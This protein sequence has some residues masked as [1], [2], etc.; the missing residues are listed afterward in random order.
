MYDKKL[1]NNINKKNINPLNLNPKL[2]KD[3]LNCLIKNYV[4]NHNAFISNLE[5][6]KNSISVNI[7][8]NLKNIDKIKE[9]IEN[10]TFIL[11][12]LKKNYQIKNNEIEQNTKN[13]IN[14][15]EN[16][17]K[18][19]KEVYNNED[20]ILNNLI[21]KKKENIIELLEQIKTIKNNKN[22]QLKNNLID[23]KNKI[24][25]LIEHT[26]N[27]KIKKKIINNYE[28]KLLELE[29]NINFKYQEINKLN[30]Q[31]IKSHKNYFNFKENIKILKQKIKQN[32]KFINDIVNGVTKQTPNTTLD[33]LE[34]NEKFNEQIE[35]IENNPEYNIIDYL[36]ELDDKIIILEKDINLLILKK[37]KLHEIITINKTK[38]K[39]DISNKLRNKSINDTKSHIKNLKSI[40]SSNN[41]DIENFNNEKDIVLNTFNNKNNNLNL[42]IEN[43]IKKETLI[44]NKND[45]EIN[46]ILEEYETSNTVLNNK[47]L[48][49]EENI[50]ILKVKYNKILDTIEKDTNVKNNITSYYSTKLVKLN[51]KI[52]KSKKMEVKN[53]IKNRIFK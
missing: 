38:I 36:S 32:N 17:K 27:K 16:Q 1:T 28:N 2:I 34:K 51:K 7:T 15:I 47:L 29:N 22:K 50:R 6:E 13:E 39:E 37:N 52:I 31:K 43:A 30:L 12:E 8:D 3:I 26:K 35:D 19:I 23:R 20:A 45:K 48:L 46:K 40:I 5:N 10:K 41:L 21:K 18:K 11:N 14:L 49:K 53:H 24:Y 44:K 25:N 42:Y 33:Y 4:N 9:I